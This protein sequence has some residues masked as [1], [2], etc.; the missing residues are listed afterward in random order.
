MAKE[1]EEE[2]Q[3]LLVVVSE[4]GEAVFSADCHEKVI[5]KDDPH[6]APVVTNDV[7]HSNLLCTMVDVADNTL[8]SIHHSSLYH[9]LTSATENLP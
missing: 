1:V 4:E 2:Q 7:D 9:V 3:P 8:A 5:C 6:E